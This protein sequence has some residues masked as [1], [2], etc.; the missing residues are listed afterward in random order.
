MAGI[1]KFTMPYT[2]HPSVLIIPSYGF[3]PFLAHAGPEA[4]GEDERADRPLVKVKSDG[5][6][7][8]RS[9]GRQKRLAGTAFLNSL[10]VKN[11]KPKEAICI[12]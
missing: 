4:G 7:L 1:Y 2:L 11:R 9:A 8:A 6:R 10:M 5:S 3:F 12:W